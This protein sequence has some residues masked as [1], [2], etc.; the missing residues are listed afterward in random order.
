MRRSVLSDVRE[1]LVSGKEAN[2]S[3]IRQRLP[4]ANFHAATMTQG[5]CNSCEDSGMTWQHQT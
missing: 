2:L 5:D 1:T 4:E 3:P